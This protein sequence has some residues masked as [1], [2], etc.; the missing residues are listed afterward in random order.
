MHSGMS[1]NYSQ[2][3][4]G[5]DFSPSGRAALYR[6]LALAARAPFHM[7]HFVCVIEPGPKVNYDYAERIQQRVAEELQFELRAVTAKDTIHFHVHAR[8]GKPAEEILL[9]ARDVGADLIIVGSKGAKGVGRLVLG[10]VSEKVVREALC[11]V[12]VARPKRYEHVDL[13]EVTDVDAHHHYVPPHRYYYEN[14]RL[15]LR[16]ADWPLV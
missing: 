10:S 3:V 15:N 5:F 4:V 1:T 11:T 6:A 14:N 2:V 7:L 9:L 13:V 12:E 16:P 8:I